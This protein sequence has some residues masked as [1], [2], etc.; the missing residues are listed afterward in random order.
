M[1]CFASAKVG[2]TRQSQLRDPAVQLAESIA[3]ATTNRVAAE[4]A[5][6]VNSNG[7]I[8]AWV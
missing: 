3:W 1:R 5:W 8:V 4:L 7:Y 2:Q 6:K